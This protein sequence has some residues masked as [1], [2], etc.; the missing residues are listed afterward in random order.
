MHDVSLNTS[1]K[2]YLT[3]EELEA[4]TYEDLR[5]AMARLLVEEKGYPKECLRPRIPVT[6]P[7]D[8]RNYTRLLDLV[9]YGDDGSP[10]LALLFC[11]GV[12]TTYH[13]EALAVARLLPDGPAPLVI[14]TDT[15][16]AIILEVNGGTLLGEGMLAIPDWNYMRHLAATHQCPPITEE[17]REREKRILYAYSESLYACCGGAACAI[18]AKGGR[19]S[20]KD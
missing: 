3:G 20:A 16:E 9:A 19:F 1:I 14:V 6:V 12:V 11:P 4:T 2:D 13:R 5:Q 7:I 8:G 18:A 10:L 17:R 15:K